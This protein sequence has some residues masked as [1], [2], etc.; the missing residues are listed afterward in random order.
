MFCKREGTE[1]HK[2]CTVNGTAVCPDHFLS[3]VLT[4]RSSETNFEES[5]HHGVQVGLG[6]GLPAELCPVGDVA[7][8]DV[9]GLVN[10]EGVAEVE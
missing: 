1:R 5:R 7:P 2:L 9:P 6:H 8:H 10:K 4:V 3:S